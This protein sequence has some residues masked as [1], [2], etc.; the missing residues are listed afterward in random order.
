MNCHTKPWHRIH[1][2]SKVTKLYIID[3]QLNILH[4]NLNTDCFITTT[5]VYTNSVK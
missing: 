4:M 3:I 1:K 2:V 5:V